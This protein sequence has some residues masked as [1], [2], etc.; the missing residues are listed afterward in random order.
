MGRF[1]MGLN[2]D[3]I[4][5]A[6]IIEEPWEHAIIDNCFGHA[7]IL[8]SYIASENI[9]RE[10]HKNRNKILEKYGVYRYVGSDTYVTWG[11]QIQ[12]PGGD[13]SIHNDEPSKLWSMVL[14]LLPYY[15]GDGTKLYDQ[16]R[17]L[18]KEIEWKHNRA[19]VFSCDPKGLK[20]WHSYNNT[21]SHYRVSIVFN[22]RTTYDD[23]N[24]STIKSNDLEWDKT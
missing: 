9:T 4:L 11:I 23:S 3:S 1:K 20:S 19:L 18:V 8:W 14:Y 12:D 7:P 5:N 2:I 10:L 15:N 17:K 6:K 22:I 13:Y 16:D 21:S 24:K